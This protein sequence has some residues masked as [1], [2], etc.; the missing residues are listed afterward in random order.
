MLVFRSQQEQVLRDR[1]AK[2]ILVPAMRSPA[3]VVPAKVILQD[4]GFDPIGEIIR[5]WEDMDIYCP[6]CG[7][8]HCICDAVIYAKSLDR[9]EDEDVCE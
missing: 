8:H 6:Y 2:L 7:Y 5:P 4:N 1:G 9:T 3:G